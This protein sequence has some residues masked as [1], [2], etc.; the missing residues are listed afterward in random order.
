MK[1]KKMLF[2]NTHLFRLLIHLSQY[3]IIVVTIKFP[4]L[5]IKVW[6]VVRGTLLGTQTRICKV[7]SV[8]FDIRPRGV[9]HG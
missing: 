5:F 7:W 9:V 3:I 6:K 2:Q 8:S 4:I 1:W